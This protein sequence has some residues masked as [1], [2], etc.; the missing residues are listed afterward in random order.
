MYDNDV[1]A[2]VD[3]EAAAAMAAAGY[4]IKFLGFGRPAYRDRASGVWS[5]GVAIGGQPAGTILATSFEQ[6]AER[7]AAFDAARAN[8]TLAAW[9]AQY[10]RERYA[11]IREAGLRTND[12]DAAW[13]EV[14]GR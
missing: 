10:L 1:A 9:H 8:G 11:V 5:C 3:P 2:A 12:A 6:L 7:V 13:A 14:E 4:D